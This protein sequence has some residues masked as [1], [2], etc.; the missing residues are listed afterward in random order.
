MAVNVECTTTRAERLPDGS[1]IQRRMPVLQFNI[2]VAG[3]KSSQNQAEGRIKRPIAQGFGD[4][5]GVSEWRVQSVLATEFQG[6]TLEN[7]AYDKQQ[8]K[9]AC[10][11]ELLDANPEDELTHDK[12]DSG[13]D[14]AVTKILSTLVTKMCVY[15]SKGVAKKRMRL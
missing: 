15:V 14:K 6:Y 12:I 10:C 9:D 5:D 4:V 13:D 1:V 2:D 11:S 8:L 7:W 3:T